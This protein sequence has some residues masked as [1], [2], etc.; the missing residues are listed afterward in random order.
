LPHQSGDDITALEMGT[1]KKLHVN[2]NNLKR[3]W[4]ASQRSTKVSIF[5]LFSSRAV[6]H[7]HAITIPLVDV[8]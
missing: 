3:A 5:V 4:E 7:G 6:R 8:V 1:V 2:Q